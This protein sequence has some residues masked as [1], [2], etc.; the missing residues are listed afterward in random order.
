VA[1]RGL[2]AANKYE[3]NVICTSVTGLL[4]SGVMTLKTSDLETLLQVT[5]HNVSGKTLAIHA[6]L[7]LPSSTAAEMQNQ[8][9][10]LKFEIITVNKASTSVCVCGWY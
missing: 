2:K 8:L 6:Y 5:R 1:S 3:N 9:F 4:V 10:K 7:N